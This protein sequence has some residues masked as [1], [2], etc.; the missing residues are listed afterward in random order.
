MGFI[1]ISA[2]HNCLA[3]DVTDSSGLCPPGAGLDLPNGMLDSRNV[4]VSHSIH[5]SRGF[6]LS[7]QTLPVNE[8]EM[9]QVKPYVAKT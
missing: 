8:A 9:L 3:Y 5:P 6:A 7:T 1:R 2:S 4:S